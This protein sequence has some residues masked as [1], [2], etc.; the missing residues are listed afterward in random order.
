MGDKDIQVVGYL[1]L[2]ARV[3]DFI[4]SGRHDRRAIGLMLG[5]SVDQ[6]NQHCSELM[7]KWVGEQ[8]KKNRDRRLMLIKMLET[9]MYTAN[10]EYKKSMRP[11]RKVVTEYVP[12][13]C[14]AC[15]GTGKRGRGRCKACK[16][17]TKARITKTVERRNGDPSY[18][19]VVLACLREIARLEGLGQKNRRSKI[20]VETDRSL[21]LHINEQVEAWANAPDSLLLEAKSLADR[22]SEIRKPIQKVVVAPPIREPV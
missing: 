5:I 13:T 7:A 17:A 15:G 6:V 12:G 21:H 2:Q 9:L 14:S 18:L 8:P 10:V 20:E 22:L 16:P 11:G 19:H 1:K 4:L 3:E